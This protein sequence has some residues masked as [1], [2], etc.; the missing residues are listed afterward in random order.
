MLIRP[1]RPSPTHMYRKSAIRT[2]SHET[3]DVRLRHETSRHETESAPPT[4]FVGRATRHFTG[5]EQWLIK[6]NHVS[7]Y[8]IKTFASV[9]SGSQSLLCL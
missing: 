7:T 8:I 2:Y 4:P 1:A 9:T 3:G 6:A 5:L